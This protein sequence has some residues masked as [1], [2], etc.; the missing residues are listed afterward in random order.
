MQGLG[1]LS[2]PKL[3]LTGC[4]GLLMPVRIPAV[5]CSALV[6]ISAVK[7]PFESESKLYANWGVQCLLGLG[8]L[9]QASF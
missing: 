9:V 7:A 2:F 5:W 3:P 6:Q 4:A 1:G 8:L